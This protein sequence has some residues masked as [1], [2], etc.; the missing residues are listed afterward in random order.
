MTKQEFAAL[1][2]GDAFNING[3]PVAP[4]VVIDAWNGS[5]LYARPILDKS[6]MTRARFCSDVAERYDLVTTKTV[7]EWKQQ[8]GAK[9]G[10]TTRELE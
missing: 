1:K 3:F 8:G 7:E 6:P 2:V 5:A 10:Y 9:I 4:W